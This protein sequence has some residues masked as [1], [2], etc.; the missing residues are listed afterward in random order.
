MRDIHSSNIR[1]NVKECVLHLPL[2]VSLTI[3]VL[4]QSLWKCDGVRMLILFNDVS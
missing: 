3:G 4:S 2:G 1:D